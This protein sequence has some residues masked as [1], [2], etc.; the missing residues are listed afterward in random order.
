MHRG[1]YIIRIIRICIVY[2][3]KIIYKIIRENRD[4]FKVNFEKCNQE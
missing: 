3:L 4:Y 1:T 2:C